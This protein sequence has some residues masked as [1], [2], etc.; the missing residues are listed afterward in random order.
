MN[1]PQAT[2]APLPTCMS[3]RIRFETQDLQRSHFKTDWHLYNLKR[4]VAGFEPVNLE[5]FNQIRAAAPEIQTNKALSSY[6]PVANRSESGEPRNGDHA[7]TNVD[8]DGSDWSDCDSDDLVEGEY[9]EEEAKEMLARVIKPEVCLFCDKK[10][11]SPKANVSHMDSMH[12][13]FVPEEQYVVDLEGLL[14]YLGFKVGAG[15]TCIWCNKQ[16]T[17]VHG[18]R[19]HMLY[20]D[21]CRIMF[22]QDK[23]VDEFKEFYDYSSQETIQMKPLNQLMISKKRNDKRA[24]YN[25][26]L[27][28]TR[29]TRGES[30]DLV[31]SCKGMVAAGSFQAKNI[32]KFNAYHAKI[33]LRTGMANNNTMRGRLRQQ[34]PI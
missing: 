23:A 26:A 27:A 19:L 8:A 11:S 18:V 13:F 17:S 16:F 4:K 1:A 28:R 25:R 7:S 31:T 12:G 5:S 29:A 34:N 30:K 6:N 2:K 32:K 10:S 22:D 24:E 14:E 3:C 33:L 20:K 21:H 15:A 9:D